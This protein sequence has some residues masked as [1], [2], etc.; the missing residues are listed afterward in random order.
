MTGPVWE[1]TQRQPERG[2]RTGKPRCGSQAALKECSAEK[3]CNKPRTS[4][5]EK[6]GG[7][8]SQRNGHG[9]RF[10]A[11][12]HPLSQA[13]P[14]LPPK[15]LH[16]LEQIRVLSLLPTPCAHA[17]T[18]AH[19]LLLPGMHRKPRSTPSSLG[20]HLPGFLGSSY[21]TGILSMS[22]N[23]LQSS[24]GSTLLLASQDR[25]NSSHKLCG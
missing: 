13:H 9:G 24:S 16:S 23:F 8:G 17:C 3:G 18:F 5:C 6:R 7:Q 22:P 25:C 1:R 10:S 12:R 14:P 2:W 11:H 15:C 4:G 20:P 19:P 21:P